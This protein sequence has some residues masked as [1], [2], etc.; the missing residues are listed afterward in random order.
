MEKG[1]RRVI[2]EDPENGNN[3]SHFLQVKG[4]I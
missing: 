2:E 1:G 4:M 3:M